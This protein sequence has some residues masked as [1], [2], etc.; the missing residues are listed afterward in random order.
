MSRVWSD[1][2]RSMPH[3]WPIIVY[4][5]HYINYP[6]LNWRDS[7][8]VTCIFVTLALV[9]VINFYIN[10]YSKMAWVIQISLY[11]K[12]YY[13]CVRNKETTLYHMA[14]ESHL[15][16]WGFRSSVQWHCIIWWFQTFQGI[17]VLLSSRVMQS[18]PLKPNAPWSFK[19]LGTTQCNKTLSLPVRNYQ[20]HCC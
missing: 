19:M 18:I 8:C 11:L 4:K 13:S 15:H 10:V 17:T 9:R 7:Y 3:Y 2:F 12:F 16:G 5:F 14:A 6:F 1:K 20:Q